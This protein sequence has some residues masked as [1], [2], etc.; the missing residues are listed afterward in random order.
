MNNKFKI[1]GHDDMNDFIRISGAEE[2]IH[3]KRTPITLLFLFI[4]ISAVAI[5]SEI[6]GDGFRK[7]IINVFVVDEDEEIRSIF[8]KVSY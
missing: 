8:N 3:L 5:L 6:I 4:L 7:S 1:P 2:V